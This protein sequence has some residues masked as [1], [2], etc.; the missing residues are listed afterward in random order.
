MNTWKTMLTDALRGCGDGAEPVEQVGQA[1]REL[2]FDHYTYGLWL[3]L[4]LSNPCIQWVGNTPTG[5]RR[6]Y[7]RMRYVRHDPIVRHA[8][9]SRD[10]LVWT[11]ELF[12]GCP[13]L[14]NDAREH[15]LRAGWSQACINAPGVRGFLTLSRAT[16]MPEAELADKA[17]DLR[18]CS[19]VAHLLLS[20]TAQRRACGPVELTHR[21]IEV[22][23]WTGDGKTVTQISAI[24]DISE[25]TVNYH[26]R[27]AVCKLR[28]A[29]KT[30]AV[31]LALAQG[32]LGN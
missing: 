8:L 12:A 20:P 14:Q 6:R 23:R 24:L 9:R 26:L 4:P 13:D 15:G 22:L 10:P 5:W 16:P 21:E 31:V 1:A 29:N 11:D 30:S 27:R 2:G 3:P 18:W 17:E 25:N 28:A 7:C 32:L 19:S